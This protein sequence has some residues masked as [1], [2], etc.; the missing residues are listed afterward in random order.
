MTFQNKMEDLCRPI[1]LYVCNLWIFKN[2]G[3]E[4]PEEVVVN[5]INIHL[6]KI[7]ERCI[8]DPLLHRDF[9]TVEKSLI[10][11]IDYVIKEGNFSF[12]RSWKTLSKKYGE[13][14]GDDKFFD[15]LESILADPT[16]KER[17]EL[18]YLIMGLGFDGSY[19][20]NTGNVE[21]IMRNCTTKMSDG[22]NINSDF[23]T[24][25]QQNIQKD[26]SK[27]KYSKTKILLISY[28]SVLFLLIVSLAYN[29]SV[30]KREISPVSSAIEQAINSATQNFDV[31]SFDNKNQLE[32]RKR[33]NDNQMNN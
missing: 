10:F 3:Y 11:F 20:G 15:I 25:Y 6:G 4:T 29:Y 12:S 2:K 5:D 30:F 16:A 18:L 32:S 28:A 33:S 17:I 8:S 19:R 23:I 27:E 14:S 31:Y 7:K 13:L 1:I 24:P 26:D 21:G 22:I 9:L